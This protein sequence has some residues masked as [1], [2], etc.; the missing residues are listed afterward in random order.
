M[1]AVALPPL[2]RTWPRGGDPPGTRRARR[3]LRLVASAL[4]FFLLPNLG[5]M[6][7]HRLAQRAGQLPSHRLPIKNFAEVDERLWRGGAP[8]EEG[9]RAL[10]DQGVTTVVD[11]RAEE[12]IDPRDELRSELGITR[13]HLPLRD[14]QSPT[15]A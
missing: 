10:A 11:L 5:I 15:L 4:A 1:T 3:G 8:T 14:G 2:G 7:M 12:G 13:V 6:L 9:Y